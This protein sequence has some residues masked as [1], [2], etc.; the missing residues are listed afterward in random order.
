MGNL[1]PIN[2]GGYKSKL[3]LKPPTEKVY[4][5]AQLWSPFFKQKLY[6]SQNLRIEEAPKVQEKKRVIQSSDLFGM[7]KWPF[8][9]LSDLQLGDKKATS[10]NH[11]ESFAFWL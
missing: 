2:F 1:S 9:G 6:Q 7:V 11:L 4:C 3:P 8:Q 5:L 10:K